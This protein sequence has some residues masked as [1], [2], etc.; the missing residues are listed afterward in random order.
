MDAFAGAI[1]LTLPIS[2]LLALYEF[3][4]APAGI[5]RAK[6]KVAMANLLYNIKR[7][8]FWEH[9][10]SHM[11]PT[12]YPKRWTAGAKPVCAANCR[13][14]NIN[15][16]LAAPES[17]TIELISIGW[18]GLRPLRGQPREGFAA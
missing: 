8:I 14:V 18:L 10:D 7:L 5:A 9:P 13:S 4:D 16:Q 17:R 6:T 11:R 1:A 12:A 3:L 2:I 15:D